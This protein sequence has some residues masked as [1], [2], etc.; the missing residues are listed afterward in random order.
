MNEKKEII[1]GRGF[2]YMPSPIISL[3]VTVKQ[4]YNHF[5]MTEAIGK[6]EKVHPII[7]NV[8]VQEDGRL[9]FKNVGKHVSVIEYEDVEVGNWREIIKTVISEVL[10]ISE[11]SGVK[12]AVLE[13]TECFDLLVMVHHIYGDGISIKCIM[14]DL[15]YMYCT[16][17]MLE[18]KEPLPELSEAY[19]T[20]DT[21]IPKEMSERLDGIVRMWNDR[22][23]TFSFE[24]FYKMNSLHNRFVRYELLAGE[25]EGDAYH[26]LKNR[27][28][29]YQVT[30]N[31]AL[32]AAIVATLGTEEG[33]DAIIP[34]NTRPL[35]GVNEQM[36]L[37]NFASSIR[38]F[39]SYD[40][41]MDFWDNVV[42]IHKELN[43]ARE[44]TKKVLEN[45]YS[46]M[47]LDADIY[48]I[49][50]HTQYGLYKDEDMVK[51][52]RDILALD[53]QKRAFDF[54][55][56]GKL[57]LENANKDIPISGCY[58]IP[59]YTITCDYTF[60]AVSLENSLTLS[61]VYTVR[62]MSPDRAQEMMNQI[63][64]Y[65]VNNS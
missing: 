22:K 39:L 17:E 43:E 53:V 52:L 6:L 60:G 11:E 31:S 19:L 30:I 5:Q 54:S 37:A 56:I 63:V 44:D 25:I 23:T 64:G 38:T 9:W 47:R 42:A 36:G 41:D 58:L 20:E 4:K 55:N 59:N 57:V 50:Y 61:L 13:H 35:L 1:V 65:L 45:L 40:Y 21:R 3:K 33:L 14:S 49:G 18:I 29:L 10:N 26:K 24:T 62:R 34:V 46:F 51:A 12:I 27:C 48:G 8:V 32:A 7:N 16:G 28:R 2:Y 15:L